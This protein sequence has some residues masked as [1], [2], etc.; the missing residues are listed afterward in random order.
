MRNRIVGALAFAALGAVLI[1]VP[2]EAVVIEAGCV[3]CDG[4]PIW[5][6]GLLVAAGVLLALAILWLPP[7]LARNVRS[8]RLSRLIVV[9]GWV[10]LTIA[11]VLAMRGL[12]LVLGGT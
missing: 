4:L 10:M 7:R 11:F 3:G 1:A 6:V 2:A 9:G 8:P 12:V 5:L